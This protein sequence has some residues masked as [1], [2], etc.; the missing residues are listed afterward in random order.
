MLNIVLNKYECI[1]SY[2]FKKITSKNNENFMN[3]V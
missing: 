2:I 1:Y 3:L